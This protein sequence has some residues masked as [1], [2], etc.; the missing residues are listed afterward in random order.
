MRR[1]RQALDSESEILCLRGDLSKCKELP[2]FNPDDFLGC[3]IVRERNGTPQRAIVKENL[4]DEGKFLI[5]FVNGGEE[6]MN[7]N[8]IIKARDKEGDQLWVHK[9]ILD[10]PKME[11]GNARSR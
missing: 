1:G 5:E 3:N 6:L 4:E 10:H 8:N 7:H 11:G 2:S 9:Q